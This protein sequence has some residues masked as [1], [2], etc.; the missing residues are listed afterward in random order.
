MLAKY[1]TQ[2]CA[3]AQITTKKGGS[4]SIGSII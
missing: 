4:G 2:I 1:G 3:K